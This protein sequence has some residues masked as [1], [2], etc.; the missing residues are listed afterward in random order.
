MTTNFKR[1]VIACAV[2]LLTYVGLAL[3]SLHVDAGS[4][5]RESVANLAGTALVVV[6]ILGGVIYAPRYLAQQAQQAATKVLEET[7]EQRTQQI[8]REARSV[9]M[10]A[11]GLGVFLVAAAIYECFFTPDAQYSRL[12]SN[13]DRLE[14]RQEEVITD[15]VEHGR[16]PES[17]RFLVAARLKRLHAEADQLW[18]ETKAASALERVRVTP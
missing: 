10:N 9:R 18:P 7:P 1:L 15:L 16:D 12:R 13:I 4:P 2:L 14:G 3:S 5:W 17:A 8:T 6:V 11:I